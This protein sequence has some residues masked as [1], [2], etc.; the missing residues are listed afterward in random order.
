LFEMLAQYLLTI[1]IS[2]NLIS[3]SFC[4]SVSIPKGGPPI[5][6]GLQGNDDE[7]IPVDLISDPSSLQARYDNL[8]KLLSPGNRRYNMFWTSFE[9]AQPSSPA[10]ISCDSSHILTPAN[11]SDRIARGYHNYHCYRIAQ[12]ETFDVIFEEDA[13]IGSVSTA[14]V[15]GSPDFA[16][17]PL[18]TGFPWPPN[19]NFRLGCI[20]WKNFDDWEDYINLLIERWRAPL[21]SGKARLSGLC[22]WNEIQSM[23]WSDPSPVL[24]NRW[25][26]VPWTPQQLSTYTG[27]IAELFI[28]AGRASI[29]QSLDGEGV[30]LWLSTD[31]FVTAPP[32]NNGDVGHI[33]LYTFLD[34][35]WPQ[36]SNASF[37]WGVCVHP[38]DNGDPRSDLSNQGIYT[39]VNLKSLVAEYQCTKL[40]QVLGV[41]LAECW[42]W[43]QTQ[44]WASEQGWPI[45]PGVNKSIQ[46]RNICLAHGLSMA[47]GL[48]SV[49]HNTFQTTESSSQGGSGD[50]SLIDEP[51]KC[52]AT[53]S[54]CTGL[55]TFD[56]YVATAPGVFGVSSNH[57][58]CSK[59]NV[60]CE[61]GE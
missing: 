60:G 25:N 22:I 2:L 36:V 58:C 32:L 16:I 20:P 35:F 61:G 12:L 34:S 29:R 28:R 40:N 48:W 15:Y 10:P 57:Y 37:S 45:S 3:E 52:L 43:P 5:I 56:A 54:N 18:C 33:G 31:H 30:M 39:F 14:I 38:Y 9:D 44:M 26:G 1:F 41:P 21:G 47:Q 24:P 55:E 8:E 7:E 50:F 59:W 11:E 17:D 27:A 19:P 23:G 46:A 4:L 51:P 49:T 42:Q 13:R 53:L 6:R